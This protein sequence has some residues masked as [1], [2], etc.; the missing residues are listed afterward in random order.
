[1][2]VVNRK[3]D[4]MFI[5]T[6]SAIPGYQS[7]SALIIASLKYDYTSSETVAKV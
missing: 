5:V 7:F 1:M 4:I 3:D 2:L 6:F